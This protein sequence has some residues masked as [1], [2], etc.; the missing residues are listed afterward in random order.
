MNIPDTPVSVQLYWAKTADSLQVVCSV[1][2]HFIIQIQKSKYPTITT[3]H[4]ED[5]NKMEYLP[6]VSVQWWWIAVLVNQMTSVAETVILRPTLRDSATPSQSTKADTLHV[7][8][9][10]SEAL[11][12]SGLLQVLLVTAAGLSFLC[13]R[14]SRE[15]SSW[16]HGP[17]IS[18]PWILCMFVCELCI[19]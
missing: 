9:M 1:M 13:S 18:R 5:M 11:S 16:T 15:G 12:F 17:G 14:T 10:V 8:I 4:E 2:Q 3:K 19:Y 7:L 6:T